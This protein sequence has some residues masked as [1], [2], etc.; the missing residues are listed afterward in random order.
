MKLFLP[1]TS[2]HPFAKFQPSF[3]QVGWILTECE[4][5]LACYCTKHQ[6]QILIPAQV[7]LLRM[8]CILEHDFCDGKGRLPHHLNHHLN[9]PRTQW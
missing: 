4:G 9:R 8:A 7:P 1:V 5:Q 6:E 2:P 3:E